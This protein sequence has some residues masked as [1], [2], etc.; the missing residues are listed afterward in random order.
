MKAVGLGVRI[1]G[2]WL[3][4]D[5][6]FEIGQDEIVGLSAPSG[7]GKSTLAQV[8]TG[9]RSPDEGI[10][11]LPSGAQVFGPSRQTILV[12]QEDDLFP[13][14][15]VEHQIRAGCRTADVAELLRLTK[16]EDSAQ[17]YP[18]QL[19]GGMKKRLALAR[20]LA[21]K[22]LLLVL[23]ET[24]SSLD[25]ALKRDLARELQEVWRNRG[26]GVLVISHN[27][28]EIEILCDRQIALRGQAGHGEE[29][30]IQFASRTTK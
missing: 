22:P 13:W 4:R 12:H 14:L 25:L 15:T 7:S 3:F 16:L 19:S 30:G 8:L 24:F 26:S 1:D 6:S 21:V 2:R 28:D 27:P 20:A 29:V 17:L 5:L 11:Q 18:H 10:V 9:H 23:D